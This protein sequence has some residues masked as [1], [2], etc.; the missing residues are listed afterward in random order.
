MASSSRE[1]KL[2]SFVLARV[3]Q[4]FD[5]LQQEHLGKG[6]ADN[7][8]VGAQRVGPRIA[9]AQ[10]IPARPIARF[11]ERLAGRSTSHE[12]HVALL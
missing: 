8:Q 7:P 1:E 2:Q 11:G 3:L 9:E 4:T 10:R 6:F 12:I 5:V